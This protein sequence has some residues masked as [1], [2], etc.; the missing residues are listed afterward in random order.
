MFWDSVEI[1]VQ[2]GRGG[3]GLI[4][5]RHEKYVPKGGPDG[6]NGGDGG[7]IWLVADHAVN[8]LAAYARQR[9]W[10]AASG[11][12]GGRAK[13]HGKTAADLELAVPVGTQIHDADG[14]LL[15]D[16][17]ADGDRAIVVQGGRGGFGNAHFTSSIRQTP[18]QAERGQ[19]GEQRRL[20][21]ELKLVADV[22]LV[23]LPSV[24]KSTLLSRL[25]AA[26]PKIA[27]Y[28]F[29]TTV[30]Q[31][32]VYQAGANRLLL[33]DVPGLIAGAHRGKGLGDAFLRHIERSKVILHLLDATRPD[34]AA[35][36][37]HVRH[38]LA[39]FAAVLATKPEVVVV[40]KGDTLTA[41]AR[42]T[43]AAELAKQLGKPVQVISAISGLG[44]TRLLQLVQQAAATYQPPTTPS[45]V[46]VLTLADLAP[47]AISITAS[48]DGYQVQGVAIERLAEQTDFS[49][50]EASERFWWIFRRLGGVKQLER[51]HARA[52]SKIRVGE[53]SV[54]WPG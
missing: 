29:T 3:D 54:S 23:G 33:V 28:P 44:I 4:S 37:R 42:R 17:T 43:V 18:R 36:Y 25:T 49:N 32:G 21:L 53:Q 16:L 5:F 47:R 7:S 20:R 8:T 24:G 38:E 13:R 48:D 50:P 30:P 19:P 31:L 51:L 40:T 10:Q 22:C 2:A 6:G 15:A 1:S 35:D 52:G 41:P 34:P 9:Q 11:S 46:P 27:D 26:R 45:V 14:A 39:A 12:P